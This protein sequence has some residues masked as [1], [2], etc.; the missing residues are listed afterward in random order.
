MVEAESKSNLHLLKKRLSIK[1]IWKALSRAKKAYPI[2]SLVNIHSVN[3]PVIDYSLR[4][5]GT[6]FV[7]LNLDGFSYFLQF[8]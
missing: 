4:S 8:R 6:L 1:N 2:G 5:D 3:C 7:V